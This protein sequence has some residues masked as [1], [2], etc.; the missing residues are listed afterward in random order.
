MC[1]PADPS[2][3]HRESAPSGWRGPHSARAGMMQTPVYGHEACRHG[4]WACVCRR[5]SADVRV[6]TWVG[7]RWDGLDGGVFMRRGNT[8][9]VQCGY[10][11]LPTEASLGASPQLPAREGGRHSSRHE[12]GVATAPGTRG[13][14]PQLPARERGRHSSRRGSPQRLGGV[15][16]RSAPHPP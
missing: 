14:S 7:Q 15:K 1:C 12:R 6:R 9:A 11:Q 8:S 13:G 10:G 16:R 4:V 2:P 3:C 5:V